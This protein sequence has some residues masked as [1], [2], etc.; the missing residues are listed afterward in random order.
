MPGMALS[1]ELK[2]SHGFLFI[3]SDGVS[4]AEKGGQGSQIA[5]EQFFENY[6]LT[7]PQWQPEAAGKHLLYEI[8]QRLYQQGLLEFGD[9]K[10]GFACTFTCL[11][12][13]GKHAHFFHVGDTRLYLL[14]DELTQL[15]KDHSSPGEGN[16]TY[17]DNALGAS[18]VAKVDYSCIDL[19]QGDHFLLST[20]GI[21]DELPQETLKN[22]VEKLNAEVLSKAAYEAG[23]TDN[24]SCLMVSVNQCRQEE[25]ISFFL[26]PE[27]L[28]S[29]STLDGI[30]IKKFLFEQNSC[31]PHYRFYKGEEIE[32][33]K[34]YIVKYPVL[35]AEE[36]T[37]KQQ[38][39]KQ[40]RCD[41]FYLELWQQKKCKLPHILTPTQYHGS[42]SAH[43]CL[44]SLEQAFA[45]LSDVINDFPGLQPQILINWVEQILSATRE[46]K[47]LGLNH[48][49]FDPQ[50]FLVNREGELRFISASLSHQASDKSYYIAP[51]HILYR[52]E[53]RPGNINAS[54]DIRSEIFSTAVFIYNQLTGQHPYRFPIQELSSPGDLERLN[55]YPSLVEKENIPLWF[56]AT[57]KKA[58]SLYEEERYDTLEAFVSDLKSPNPAYLESKFIEQYSQT[59]PIFP[60]WKLLTALWFSSIVLMGLLLVP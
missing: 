20:D 50:F 11:L 31:T 1:D 4:A 3:I 59:L 42:P 26:L 60:L 45:P 52:K 14:R 28:K 53:R 7:P 33:G 19:K 8:N 6:Y 10:R 56:D 15:T 39:Y 48:S 2:H 32:T 37:E 54:Q 40:K 35:N 27:D 24:L 13:K 47:K 38:R 30:K 34:E 23:S 18:R 49:I 57:L 5:C 17:L 36:E 16:H 9:G 22:G 44:F 58:V 41:Q 43:Y 55:Y 25:D 21:H 46:L 29:I 51:E 12:I